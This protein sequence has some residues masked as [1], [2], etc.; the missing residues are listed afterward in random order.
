M[1]NIKGIVFLT[2]FLLAL[3]FV[4]IAKWKEILVGASVTVIA[5]GC[6]VVF[7]VI[8]ALISKG[9]SGDRWDMD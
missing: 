6:V 9:F 4:V 3:L 8:G 7:L 2:V 5:I 1:K